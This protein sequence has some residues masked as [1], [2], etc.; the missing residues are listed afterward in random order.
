MI[1]L[2]FPRP[3][4]ATFLTNEAHVAFDPRPACS[5]NPFYVSTLKGVVFGFADVR[6][7]QKICEDKGQG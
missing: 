4:L 7:M 1:Q 2:V 6:Q 5:A 3:N